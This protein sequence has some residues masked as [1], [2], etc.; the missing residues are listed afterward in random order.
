MEW[1]DLYIC[2]ETNYSRSTKPNPKSGTE[3]EAP[4]GDL[5]SPTSQPTRPNDA[6]EVISE[7]GKTAGKHLVDI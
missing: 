7:H 5:P 1:Q 2:E 4:S 3:T 6:L